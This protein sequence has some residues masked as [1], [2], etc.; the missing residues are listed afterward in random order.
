MSNFQFLDGTFLNDINEM[1]WIRK[2]KSN[3]KKSFILRIKEEFTGLLV[4]TILLQEALIFSKSDT[5]VKQKKT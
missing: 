1:A 4:V 5:K 3:A 2:F